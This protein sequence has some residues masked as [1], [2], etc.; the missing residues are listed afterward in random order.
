M[1]LTNYK[2]DYSVTSFYMHLFPNRWAA[3]FRIK[4]EFL[5]KALCN[6]DDSISVRSEANCLRALDANVA[7]ELSWWRGGDGPQVVHACRR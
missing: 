1:L 3:Y 4:P 5:I 6:N 2:N 7:G